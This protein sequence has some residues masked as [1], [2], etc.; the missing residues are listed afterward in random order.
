MRLFRSSLVLAALSV[1]ACG[2]GG[3]PVTPP[4]PPPG[5]TVDHVVIDNGD[6]TVNVAD[7]RQ[8]QVRALTAAG[9]LVTDAV[10]TYTSSSPAA[11]TVSPGGLVTALAPGSTTITA[12]SAG[13][14]AS[15]TVTI[16][17]VPVA[18]ISVEIQRQVIKTNDTTRVVATLRDASNN[19]LTGRTI[20]WQSG[21]S[22]I[23]LVG[24]TGFVFGLRPGGP[25]TISASVEGKT[26]SVSVLITPA[27][28]AVVKVI[29]DSAVIAPG[30]AVQFGVEVRDEFGGI[31]ENP[32]VIW[33]SSAAQIASVSPTG[34]VSASQL[35]EA[36][37]QAT[38]DGITGK[39]A[40][41]VS[42]PEVEKFRISVDN[43]LRYSVT[44][45]QNGVAVGSAAA[46]RITSIDRPVTEHA[47]LGW[48]LNRPAGLGEPMSGALPNIDNP[49]G[50][51]TMTV[52]NVLA[53]GSTYFTP[54]VRDLSPNKV[55]LDFPVVDHA[56]QCLCFASPLESVS[57]EY[58]Y[59]LLTPASIMEVYRDTDFIRTGPKLTFP[60]IMGD[61]EAGSGVWRF[62]LIIAP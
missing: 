8:L 38:V 32:Q 39:S 49:T 5:T 16:Q 17:L 54:Q 21:D 34:L 62:D 24:P 18:T 58:G 50:T 33:A 14:S 41:S 44:I 31:V 7:T 26:A 29:P 23:V 60:V 28:V 3:T 15:I 13:K 6:F 35:G 22:S 20:N 45:T 53:D 47:V 42:V 36:L 52:T 30:T 19:I 43:R 25:V 11:A 59:W 1:A 40:V 48:T 51:I 4:P 12:T 55:L 61:V 56:T 2:G 9:T 37:I 27:L 10:V 46:N 57:R